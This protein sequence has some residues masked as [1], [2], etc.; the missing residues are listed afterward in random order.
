[1]KCPHCREKTIRF[2]QW[3]H[4]QNAFR[5][6][7]PYCGAVLRANWFVYATFWAAIILSIGVTAAVIISIGVERS[8]RTFALSFLIPR[9]I[10]FPLAAASWFC[11]RYVV[12]K[13]P[14]ESAGE[15][16]LEDDIDDESFGGE[17]R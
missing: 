11:G 14:S 12:E 17:N 4:A 8:L 1:M 10:I 15:D 2:D 9:S 5:W 16:A 7:C 3:K 6:I 13:D